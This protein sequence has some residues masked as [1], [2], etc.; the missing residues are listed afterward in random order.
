MISARSALAKV[1]PPAPAWVCV[2]VLGRAMRSSNVLHPM[3]LSSMRQVQAADSIG[4]AV[5]ARIENGSIVPRY[6][7]KCNEINQPVLHNGRYRKL[8]PWNV[9]QCWI[10]LII[11][12]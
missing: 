5:C 11:I 7:H 2:C 6:A 8:E 4:Y 1:T 3:S 10:L 9:R 12:G